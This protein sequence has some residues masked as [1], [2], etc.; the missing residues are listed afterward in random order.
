MNIERE[1]RG[2]GIQFE[3]KGDLHFEYVGSEK[4]VEQWG[5]SVW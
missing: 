3:G 1:H 2:K 4:P 5:E